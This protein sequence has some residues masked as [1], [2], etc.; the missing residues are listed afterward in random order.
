MWKRKRYGVTALK[1]YSMKIGIDARL[2][3]AAYGMGRY[4]ERITAEIFVNDSENEYVLFL[5]PKTAATYRTPEGARVR[6]IVS[7]ERWYG[8]R[9]Q[10][11]WPLRLRREKLDLLWVPQFNVPL[12]V[13]C[14]F[15]VTVHDMTQWYVPGTLQRWRPHHRLAF[16]LTFA[17]A[18]HRAR[19][20]IAVSQYTKDE[21]LRHFRVHSGKI[22][23]IHEG[24]GLL[25]PGGGLSPLEPR[26]TVPPGASPTEGETLS[27]YKIQNTKYKTDAAGSL[28]IHD[29]RF[30][31]HEP[32]ILAVS[33]W[34]KH[35]NFEGLLEAF[36]LLRVK[37]PDFASLKLVLVGEEDPRYSGVREAITRL[38]L[39]DG[40]VTPGAVGDRELDALYRNASVVVIP[41]FYEGFALTG[42][43]A[44]SRGTPVTASAIPALK[45]ILDDA[46][47]YFDPNN[48]AS[49]ADTLETVLTN[50]PLRAA[51]RNRGKEVVAAYSW[52]RA[53][54]E[55][56]AL[57]M[58]AG[59]QRPT[60]STTNN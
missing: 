6:L 28:M 36:A 19:A 15:V 44:I 60:T 18:V 39:Q 3:G 38:G 51:L 31:I 54:A 30:K 41:S 47:I 53:A 29:S 4:I 48:A 17:N 14:P 16:W 9:E 50:K 21:I 42:L 35:K 55:T 34:R 25:P 43:E 56:F 40:V 58:T 49:I 59:N 8:W 2:L 37:T 12:F 11:T 24:P 7:P 1:R 26:G 22:Q 57:L 10:L 46:A 20:V 33:I 45:E 5:N 27:K 23:V 32:Y 13:P 52:K